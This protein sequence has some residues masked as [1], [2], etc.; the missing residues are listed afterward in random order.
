MTCLC[1]SAL[2]FSGKKRRTRHRCHQLTCRWCASIDQHLS[3]RCA[4]HCF[5]HHAP[6]EFF[7]TKLSLWKITEVRHV[8][9]T[10]PCLC[11]LH[12]Y[13]WSYLSSYS[14]ATADRYGRY[15]RITEASF[16]RPPSFFCSACLI[17]SLYKFFYTLVWLFRCSL[18][19]V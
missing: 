14:E 5:T 16:P 8:M 17:R 13:L 3:M 2:C 4:Y 1:R 18:Q 7:G 12:R 19:V 6:K 15:H 9:L 10:I 11:R